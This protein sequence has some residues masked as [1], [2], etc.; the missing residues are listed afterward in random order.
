[1]SPLFS[2]KPFRVALAVLA[3]ICSMPLL[4][5]AADEATTRKRID[6]MEQ[7]VKD[8]QWST[9]KADCAVCY[10]WIKELPEAVRPELTKRVDAVQKAYDAFMAQEVHDNILRSIRSAVDRSKEWIKDGRDN[11]EDLDQAERMMEKHK[12]IITD[13]E[14]KEL[15]SEIAILRKQFG[16]IKVDKALERLTGD[17]DDVEKKTPE[18][19][20]A[21]K[22]DRPAPHEYTFLVSKINGAVKTLKELPQDD[23]KVKALLARATK[24]D[25]EFQQVIDAGEKHKVVARIKE[26]WATLKKDYGAG[27]E[28]EQPLAAAEWLKTSGEPNIGKTREF[29]GRVRD[30]EGYDFTKNALTKYADDA[31]V[32]AIV[33]ESTKVKQQATEKI[34]KA[35]EGLIVES[36]KNPSERTYD[37]WKY[38]AD[39]LERT[40]DGMPVKDDFVKRGKAIV[41]NWEDKVAAGQKARDELFEKLKTEAEAA[42]PAMAAK[43]PAD[44]DKPI[45]PQAILKNPDAHKGKVFVIRNAYNR[46]NWELAGGGYD[47]ALKIDGTPVAGNWSPAVGAAMDK[48]FEA[49]G[50]GAPDRQFDAVCRVD[51][52]CRVKE[53]EYSQLLQKWIPT[54]DHPGV[55]VTVIGFRG[56]A[57]SAL[58]GVSPTVTASGNTTAS[59][60]AAGA[61][62]GGGASA[63]TPAVASTTSV[64]AWVARILFVLAGLAAAGLAF[65]KARPEVATVAGSTGGAA[66]A[67]AKVSGNLDMIGIVVAVIGLVWLLTGL[68]YKDM[69]P[70]LAVT[71][72]GLFAASDL[73]KSKGVP[74]AT[75]DKLK[76]FGA[77]LAIATAA[78]VI[79]HLVV[80]QYA[81]L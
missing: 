39:S 17:V 58:D 26:Q 6:R 33:A 77:I 51:G 75:V 32:K 40:L 52:T 42:W 10:E 76:P 72:C 30:W 73:L 59:S 47:F 31:D 35:I 34:T 2:G 37:R 46:A 3:L 57:V 16:R 25:A 55:K 69:L 11:A 29:L 62:S 60:T 54:F 64:G 41:K 5:S 7:A 53:S 44:A 68:V 8:K 1:M 38:F 12:D 43:L 24:V 79:V 14:R 78:L 23:E 49:T 19:A 71:A 45:D 66:N 36:E 56:G 61:T 21:L 18:M 20:A 50:K 67:V 13:A 48:A 28:A 74:A 65:L 63:A 9:L 15:N 4:A 80:G 27:W 81:I 70:A 22:E